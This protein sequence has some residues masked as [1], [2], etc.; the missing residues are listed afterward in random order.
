MVAASPSAP[1]KLP[2]L[3]PPAN[4]EAADVLLLELGRLDAIEARNEAE[5]KRAMAKVKEEYAAKN[6]VQW[7]GRAVPIAD[8]RTQLETALSAY[9]TEHKD[10]LIDEK[11]RSV[12]LNFG[13]LAWRK[14]ADQLEPVDGQSNA[15]RASLLDRLHEHAVEAMGKFQDLSAAAL[16]CLNVQLSWRRT[17]L[18][19]ARQDKRID[20]EELRTAGGDER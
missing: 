5:C 12:K 10:E 6:V 14:Q 15:G 1:L 8:R 16:S 9:A 17:E 4:R 2:P 11:R 7:E 3:K 18:L 13:T 20:A 19:H